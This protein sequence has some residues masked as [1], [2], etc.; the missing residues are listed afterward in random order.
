M[1]LRHSKSPPVEFGGPVSQGQ[2]LCLASFV[3]RTHVGIEACEAVRMEDATD[4]VR[5]LII[6]LSNL[7]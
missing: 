7:K 3:A 6:E 5:G 2:V 1:V 4:T